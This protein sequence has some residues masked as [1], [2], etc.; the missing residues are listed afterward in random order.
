LWL[1]LL[2]AV[3]LQGRYAFSV[4][5]DTY[6]HVLPGMQREAAVKFDGM[7]AVRSGIDGTSPCD[8]AR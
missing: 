6:S 7:L 8:S 1:C 5:M 3:L 2:V 4:T